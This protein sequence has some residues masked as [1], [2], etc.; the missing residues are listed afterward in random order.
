MSGGVGS[1]SGGVS[2]S[3]IGSNGT[4]GVSGGAGGVGSGGISGVEGLGSSSFANSVSGAP[5][6]DSVPG[7]A[8][9][10]S[11]KFAVSR[12]FL[13][14]VLSGISIRGASLTVVGGQSYDIERGQG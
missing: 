4:S 12:E 11:G 13:N 9:H 1:V 5:S 8:S 10:G 3:G 2:G 6:Q 7:S 14:F